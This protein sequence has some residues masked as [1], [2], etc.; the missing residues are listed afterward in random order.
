[1][2]TEIKKV[3]EESNNGIVRQ[4]YP[5]THVDGV[6]GL[7]ELIKRNGGGSTIG[8]SGISIKDII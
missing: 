3:M 7:Y 5:E 6:I 2:G 1:M 4:V 8:G